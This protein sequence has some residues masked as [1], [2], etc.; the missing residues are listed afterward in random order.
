[1]RSGE[2]KENLK[3]R[4]NECEPPRAAQTARMRHPRKVKERARK[5]VK[6]PWQEQITEQRKGLGGIELGEDGVS[7]AE[8][9]FGAAVGPG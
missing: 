1:M 9:P 4:T 2:S 3:K 6:I 8:V 5:K 7:A